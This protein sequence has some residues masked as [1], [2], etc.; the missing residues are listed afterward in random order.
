MLTYSND[1]KDPSVSLEV[2]PVIVLDG[3]LT[4]VSDPHGSLGPA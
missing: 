2:T 1:A 3:V 4:A